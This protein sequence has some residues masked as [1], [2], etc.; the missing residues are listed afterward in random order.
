MH[1]LEHWNRVI[2]RHPVLPWQEQA[3]LAALRDKGGKRGQAALDKLVMHNLR[4]VVEH[5]ER[6]NAKDTDKHD[7]MAEGILGLR[8]AAERWKPV[9]KPGYDKPAPFTTYAYLWVRE[10]VTKAAKKMW[11]DSVSL[12]APARDGGEDGGESL[13]DTAIGGAEDETLHLDAGLLGILTPGEREIVE[14]C[15]VRATGETDEQIAARLGLSPA[16]VTMMLTR[17]VR[18]LMQAA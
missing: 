11:H 16:S 1:G 17:S 18:R 15:L 4:C 10:A 7:L 8:K 2:D 14:T 12:D 9:Q 5:V 3:A 6:M 13:R